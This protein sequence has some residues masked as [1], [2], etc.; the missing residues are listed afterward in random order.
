MQKFDVQVTVEGKVYK[1]V[2][3][4][5]RECITVSCLELGLSKSD[6]ARQPYELRAMELLHGLVNQSKGHG[7]K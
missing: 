3:Y 7:W 6:T 2:W 4:I 1:G 5:E